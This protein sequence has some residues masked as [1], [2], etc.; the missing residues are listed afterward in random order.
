[1]INLKDIESYVMLN[2]GVKMPLLGLGTYKAEDFNELNNA[3]KEALRIGYRH[4]DTASFYKNEEAVGHAL[5]ESGVSRKEIFLVNKLWNSDQGYEKT[6]KTFRTSIKKLK[7]DYLDGY[8]IHWP[9]PLNKETWRAF[10]KLY[11]EGYIRAI[12]VCNFTC[13]HLKDLME[14]AEIMPAIN[15]IEFHPR[16]VQTELIEFYKEN[17]IQIEAWSPLMRGMIFQIPLFK[18]LSQK[19]NK[20]I[21][22]IALRWDLQMGVVTIPKS[23]TLTRI[24]E[25][26]EIFDFEISA[27]DMKKFKQLNIGFRLG[28]NP[29][30]VYRNL[31][32]I[33]D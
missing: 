6:L 2:N 8:L 13:N 25:N 9:Q 3:I 12:G 20:T 28:M 32:L 23:T 30:D 26:S 31:E 17:N 1:M 21:S 27:E 24:K 11:K 29:N 5:K 19:Y 18:Q 10:E 14:T 15:Q 16:L 7:T 22:Q 4:I 33:T